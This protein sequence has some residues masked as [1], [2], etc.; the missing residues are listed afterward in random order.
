MNHRSVDG[1]IYLYIEGGAVS[2]RGVNSAG[3]GATYCTEGSNGS[4]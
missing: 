2:Q 3:S 4:S 1:N